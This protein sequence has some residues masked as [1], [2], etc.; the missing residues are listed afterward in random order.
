MK[1]EFQIKEII[2]QPLPANVK[3]EVLEGIYKLLKNSNT[4]ERIEG[5]SYTEPQ[6]LYFLK[7]NIISDTK[8][9]S[10]FSWF[11]ELTGIKS[12]GKI[13]RYLFPPLSE[14]RTLLEYAGRIRELLDKGLPLNKKS[15]KGFM[16]IEDFKVIV[17]TLFEQEARKVCRKMLK[18]HGNISTLHLAKI[19]YKKHHGF[20]SLSTGDFRKIL[21]SCC[22]ELGISRESKVNKVI[23]YLSEKQ[24]EILLFAEEDSKIT[25]KYDTESGEKSMIVGSKNNQKS[26]DWVIF[27]EYDGNIK[28]IKIKNIKSLLVGNRLYKLR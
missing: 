21:Q 20:L 5:L 4:K 11:E 27:D 14:G 6:L 13:S 22:K 16:S 3:I 19:M 1:K 17:N 18:E 24:M 26:G 2:Y 28:T 25:I 12:Y 10:I 23:T 9:V 8:K 7:D 15:D